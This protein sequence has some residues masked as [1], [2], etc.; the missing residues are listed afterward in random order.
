[1]L[2]KFRRVQLPK[3]IA[4]LEQQQINANPVRTNPTRTMVIAVLATANRC[5]KPVPGPSQLSP[6]TS[7]LG[8]YSSQLGESL[9]HRLH[10]QLT[11][12]MGEGRSQG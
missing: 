6:H 11:N 7:Q 5:G 9:S 1:M 10:L 12:C 2:C 3:V 8:L 4:K